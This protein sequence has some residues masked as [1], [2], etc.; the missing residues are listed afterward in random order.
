MVTKKEE[1]LVIAINPIFATHDFTI[2]TN[3]TSS[4]VQGQ[5]PSL[6]QVNSQFYRCNIEAT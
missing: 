2:S 4:I 5:P 6:Q 3:L 1:D